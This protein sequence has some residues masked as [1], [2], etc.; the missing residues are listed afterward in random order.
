NVLR[1]HGRDPYFPAWP[2]TLQLD[3]SN[4]ATQEAMA[5]ELLRIAGQCD[6]VRCDMA[7][8]L[9]PEVFER[10][11]GRKAEPFWPA[12]IARVR[13]R[14]PGFLFLAEVYWELEWA[15]LSQG[16]DY[17]YDKR[18]YD[19]LREG[20]A[21]RVR[22]HLTAG[23]EFQDKLARFLENHDEKRA[24]SAFEPAAHDAAAIV[25]FLSPGMRFFHQGQLEGRRKRVSPHLVRAPAEPA[26]RSRQEFYARLLQILR[27]PAVRDGDWAILE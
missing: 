2:D 12:A 13:E 3:Y 1:A 24:A 27:R 4:P 20:N 16:F 7:M 11:W 19:R 25:T 6:G 14:F 26:D 10:T 18:L 17:A 23:L 22:E 21:R 15:L 9:L 8:L 5:K